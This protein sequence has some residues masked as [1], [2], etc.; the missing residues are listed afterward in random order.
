MEYDTRKRYYVYAW[1][2]KDTGEV[3]YIGK[4]TGNRYKTRKRENKFF[5]NMLNSHD[6]EPEIIRDNLDEEEAFKLEIELIAFYRQ[7]DCRL[8]NIAPGGEN[9]PR[10][11]ERTKEWCQHISEGQKKSYI[12]NPERS[13]GNS[14]RMKA[15]L[16]SDRSEEF[17][18]KSLETRRTGEFRKEQSI[19][20]QRVL[21]TPEFH[22]RHSERMKEV[23]NRPEMV[24]R[25]KGAKNSHAQTVQQFDLN[26]NF[27]KEYETVA[28]AERETG[29]NNSKISA[30][31]RGNRKT[32]GGYKW[33]YPNPKE[34]RYTNRKNT[35]KPDN[36]KNRMAIV[37][38]T[39]QGDYIAEY[40]S[41]AEATRI[42]KFSDRTNIIANLKGRTKSA[43]GFVWKYK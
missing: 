38:Y 8:T 36:D 10:I 31:A 5:M 18:R 29:I 32:A 7:T 37:Q 3:F 41:I 4:G 17:K 6:C 13:K 23:N 33:V 16:Q 40:N 27:I 42:N 19:R 11:H 26:G 14:D 25:H 2:I 15:F 20:S 21:N 28:Q 22:K 12:E 30:V 43:Y 1:K 24:A 9:P 34:I 35:Y 39:K